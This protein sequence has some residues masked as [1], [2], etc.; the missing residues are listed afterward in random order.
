M[1]SEPE[2]FVQTDPES[3]LERAFI[4]EYLQRHG[5]AE[6]TLH[7]L[8]PSEAIP[9]MREASIY[10]SARLGEVEARAHYVHDIHHAHD[11][12]KRTA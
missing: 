9:L 3:T 4:A 8:P 5:Q 11:V 10:A 2:G 12:S 6:S 7:L 1:Q